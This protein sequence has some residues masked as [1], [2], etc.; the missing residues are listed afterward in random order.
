MVQEKKCADSPTMSK[1]CPRSPA[2]I[3]LFLGFTFAGYML[4]VICIS[5]YTVHIIENAPT[6]RT[7]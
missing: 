2:C 7:V 1:D 6:N 5:N 3:V 4:L